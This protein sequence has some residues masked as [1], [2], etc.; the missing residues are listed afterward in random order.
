VFFFC[1]TVS[2]ECASSLEKYNALFVCLV[3]QKKFWVGFDYQ[4]VFF[5]IAEKYYP[6]GKCYLPTKSF[7]VSLNHPVL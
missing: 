7:L 3:H 4:K 6:T 2:V 5:A 1:Q